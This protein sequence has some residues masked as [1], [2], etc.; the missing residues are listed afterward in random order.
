MDS[1]FNKGKLQNRLVAQGSGTTAANLGVISMQLDRAQLTSELVMGLSFSQTWGTNAPTS[2][3]MRFAFT[4]IELTSSKGTH[5]S[6]GW[7][8]FYDLM[9]AT[10]NKSTPIFAYGAGGGAAAALSGISDLHFELD[11]SPMDVLTFLDTSQLSSL[12]LKL[13]IAPDAQNAFIGGTGAVGVTAVNV[14]VEAKE[15][16]EM[17][18][19]MPFGVAN[20]FCIDM[21]ENTGVAAVS[22]KEVPLK[23]GNKTRFIMVQ[24]LDTSGARPVYTDAV[25]DKFNFKVN[26]FEYCGNSPGVTVRKKNDA[27]RGMNN[28]GCYL[29]DFGD[30]PAQYADL[31]GL[32][33]AKLEFSTLAGAPASWKATCTQVYVEGLKAL[34]Y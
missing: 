12:N 5:F 6:C 23:T 34:G 26:G 9:R 2:H 32:V 14:T 20:Q 7:P 30:D 1:A 27:N 28:V 19:A 17:K 29:L 15:Y 4:K 24:T 22:N 18:G 31:E 16:P 25:I 13:T 21:L 8:A 10:E 3:D 11:G 33:S